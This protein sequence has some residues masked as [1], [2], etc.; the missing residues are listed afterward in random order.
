[1]AISSLRSSSQRVG[2]LDLVLE[3]GLLLEQLLHLVGLHLA[4]PSPI[5]SKQQANRLGSA[6]QKRVTT[7]PIVY[8]SMCPMCSVPDGYGSISRT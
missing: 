1:M 5:S 2:G 8:T 6:L 3:L 7:S 4:E